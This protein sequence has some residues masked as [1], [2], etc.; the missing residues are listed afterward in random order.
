MGD[1][2]AVCFDSLG[3]IYI[4]TSTGL[5]IGSEDELRWVAPRYGLRGREIAVLLI[6]GYDRLWAGFRQD[7]ISRIS[8]QNLW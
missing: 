5:A 7:G 4:G 3:R 8:L 1:Y 6:D 2:R